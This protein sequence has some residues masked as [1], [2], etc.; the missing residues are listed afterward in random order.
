M[1]TVAGIPTGK[2]KYYAMPIFNTIYQRKI[3]SEERII[4]AG[5][6]KACF[7]KNQ[8][9]LRNK[10]GEKYNIVFFNQSQILH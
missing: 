5:T 1:T 2:K 7:G 4:T 10:T 8:K 9:H 3:L 6:G